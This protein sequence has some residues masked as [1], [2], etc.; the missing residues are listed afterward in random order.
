M[1]VRVASKTLTLEWDPPA[2]QF[3]TAPLALSSYRI[4]CSLHAARQWSRIGEIPASTRLQFTIHH[5]DL[6]DGAFDFAV[7]AVDVVGGESS[8]HT[9][10]DTT[11]DPTG[12]WYVLWMADNS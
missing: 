11:A 4:Y 10:L 3:P 2:V 9:S 8:L 12:G 5:A 7:T 1:P 6:G